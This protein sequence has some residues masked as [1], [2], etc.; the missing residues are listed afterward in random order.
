MNHPQLS[1]TTPDGGLRLTVAWAAWDGVERRHTFAWRVDVM[2]DGLSEGALAR[3]AIVPPV[4]T[5]RWEGE[6]LRTGTTERGAF[7]L[8]PMLCTL[9]NFLGSDAESYRSN[10]RRRDNGGD[11]Y[12][13]GESLAEIAYHYSEELELLAHEICNEEA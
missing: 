8:A 12:L 10:M 2:G 1:I 6:D 5:Q 13:F 7:A 11:S 3:G 4:V 9:L